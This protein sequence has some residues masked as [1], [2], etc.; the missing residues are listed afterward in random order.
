MDRLITGN[1]GGGGWVGIW[2]NEKANNVQEAYITIINTVGPSP[3]SQIKGSLIHSLFA[4]IHRPTDWGGGE[5]TPTAQTPLHTAY[6]IGL[7]SV[8]RAL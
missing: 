1:G 5:T 3:K 6:T 7:Y 8:P 2:L 4:D